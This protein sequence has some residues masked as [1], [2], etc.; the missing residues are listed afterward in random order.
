MV[1]LFFSSV[2]AWLGCL[3]IAFLLGGCSAVLDPTA[4]QCQ[5]NQDCKR[6]RADSVCDVTHVCI[7]PP[8]IG[9]DAGGDT[10]CPAD[11]TEGPGLFVSSCTRAT[12]VPFDNARRLTRFSADGTL[13]PLPVRP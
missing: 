7:V 4:D 11:S 13:A 1:R 5:T 9:I 2:R 8:S 6:F 10:A 3:G 12:C